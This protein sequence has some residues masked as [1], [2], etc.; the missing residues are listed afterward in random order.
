LFYNRL[1]KALRGGHREGPKKP[2]GIKIKASATAIEAENGKQN[3]QPNVE[4]ILT[5]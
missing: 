1:I 2:V 5:S 3:D 4:K